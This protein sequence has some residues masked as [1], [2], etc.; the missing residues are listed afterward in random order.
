MNG[1]VPVCWPA[2]GPYLSVCP[3]LS[4]GAQLVGGDGGRLQG[5]V[6]AADELDALGEHHLEQHGAAVGG[7]RLRVVVAAEPPALHRLT[8]ARQQHLDLCDGRGGGY[9]L[10]RARC[11]GVTLSRVTSTTA[12]SGSVR[13]GDGDGV[14]VSQGCTG[15]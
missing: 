9:S 1:S 11:H 10:V 5:G 3:Y 15:G 12:A 4:V 6:V 7:Q 2:A 13:G 8:V 14:L